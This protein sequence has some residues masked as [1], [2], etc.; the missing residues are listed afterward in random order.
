MRNLRARMHQSALRTANRIRPILYNLFMDR[1]RPVPGRLRNS[2]F[3]Y[4]AAV[5]EHNYRHQQYHGS[6]VVYRDQQTYPDP[7][8]GWGRFVRDAVAYEIPVD[9]DHH[10]G[11]LQE[12]AVRLLAEKMEEHLK[13][14]SVDSGGAM[15]PS[16]HGDSEPLS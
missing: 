6:I 1:N 5:A 13:T 3:T 10:R 8:Q 4:I 14:Q 12:P 9:V 15:A 16:V 7:L 11:L 2:Y